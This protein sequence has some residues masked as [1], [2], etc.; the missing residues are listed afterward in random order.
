M[1]GNLFGCNKVSFIAGLPSQV[2]ELPVWHRHG[3]VEVWYG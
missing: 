1:H 3:G 2:A